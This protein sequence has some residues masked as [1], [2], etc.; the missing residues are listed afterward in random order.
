MFETGG[1]MATTR[2]YEVAA[3]LPDAEGNDFTVFYLVDA[4]SQAAAWRYVAEK[5]V[6]KAVL[7]SGKRL[8]VLMSLP[9]SVKVE[10]ADG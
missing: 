7:P 10:E 6:R 1:K 2:I 9:H 4:T 5:Y 8:A 3:N